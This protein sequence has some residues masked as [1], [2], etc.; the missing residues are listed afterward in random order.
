[1]KYQNLETFLKSDK[2][3][4]DIEQF[5]YYIKLSGIDSVC[6]EAWDMSCFDMMRKTEADFTIGDVSGWSFSL[7]F[8]DAYFEYSTYKPKSGKD[9]NSFWYRHDYVNYVN[10]DAEF[11]S[12]PEEQ[13]Q[14]CIN[15]FKAFITE[16]YERRA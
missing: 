7:D 15:K 9:Y 6:D 10:G 12:F 5:V 8:K 3:E 11:V 16:Y 13:K 1:M 14:W 4:E 2:S